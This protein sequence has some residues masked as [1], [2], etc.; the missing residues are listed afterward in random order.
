MEP[1]KQGAVTGRFKE[2]KPEGLL[3]VSRD[4]DKNYMIDS[5]NIISL[6]DKQKIEPKLIEIA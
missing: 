3:V 6:E 2:L 1:A 5:Q 4:E